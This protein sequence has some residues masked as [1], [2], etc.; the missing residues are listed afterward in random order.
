MT[1][2]PKT[3]RPDTFAP[4][5]FNVKSERT[6][7]TTAKIT[8]RINE[9]GAYYYS[10]ENPNVD[11]SGEGIIVKDMNNIKENN[12]ISINNL[13]DNKSKKVYIVAKDRL[14]NMHK[15]PIEIKINGVDGVDETA[16]VL[17]ALSSERTGKETATVKFTSDESGT[18]YYSVVEKDAQA[19]VIDTAVVGTVMVTGKNTISISN[20]KSETEKDIYV[21]A[22]DVNSN[23]LSMAVKI[24]IEKFTEVPIIPVDKYPTERKAAK[25][26]LKAA[27]DRC[28]ESDYTKADW[29]ELL[30]AYE[31]GIKAIDAAQPTDVFVKEIYDALNAAI[32]VMDSIPVNTNRE[33][34]VCVSMDANTIG[35]GY[36]IKPTLVKIPKY[37][38]ASVVITDLLRENGYKWENTGTISDSFYLAQVKPVNQEDVVIADYILKAAGENS[39]LYEDKDDK[40]LGEFDYHNMSGWMYSVSD[41]SKYPSFPGV[42]SASWRMIN[43]EVMR[44]QFTV[45]GYGADLNADNKQWGNSSIVPGLGNKTDLTWDVAVLRDKYDDE[46]LEKNDTYKK[47]ME[48][49]ANPKVGQREIDKIKSELGKVNFELIIGSVGANNGLGN[50]VVEIIKPVSTISGNTATS[51]ISNSEAEKA[52]EAVKNNKA[53]EFIIEPEIKKDV[54]KVVVK[55]PKTA[56]SSLA[57][58]TEAAVTVKSNVAVIS[59]SNEALSSISNTAGTTVS[60]TAERLNK[61]KLSKENKELIG[62]KPVFEFKINVDN[63]E[64]TSFSGKI[65]IN[66]PYVPGKDEDINKLTVYYIDKNGKAVEMTGARYDKNSKSVVFATE[67]FSTF[68]IV[69]DKN[70]VLFEDIN[71]TDWF[72]PSVQF[73]TSNGLFKGVTETMF[74]PNDCMTRGMLVTSLYRMAGSPKV[75]FEN[76]FIDVENGA[77]YADAVVWAYE[78]KIVRGYKDN[79]FGT[80]DNITREQIAAIL[81]RYAMTK[82]YNTTVVSNM[83]DFTDYDKISSYALDSMEWAVTNKIIGGRS[84]NIIAPKSLATRA[85]V[86]TMLMRFVE[87]IV[88]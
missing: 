11:T 79:V 42:G 52:V 23:L 25:A 29:E 82:G 44:W 37:E 39:I 9:P 72:Y 63:K 68:A 19:P 56:I 8:F 80:N 43:G 50:K 38:K 65:T 20:L 75:K 85:E 40:A 66:L 7:D 26:Q 27:L 73:V 45:Y 33:I 46:D 15:T 10:V 86:S 30:A 18:Y 70:K 48:V 41:G 60:I 87:N 84:K 17:S 22:K 12:T 62:D 67:H 16:P 55:L 6:G 61:D 57:D 14:G 53:E 49:L 88:K 36:L 1:D 81:Y 31:D 32:L 59:I 64:V 21:L 58:D 2:V 78:N 28:D 74:K 76:K 34:T 83:N 51:T 47:A 77:W 35:L 5:I 69:Y 54:E 71:E 24:T 3:E 13:A 4:N